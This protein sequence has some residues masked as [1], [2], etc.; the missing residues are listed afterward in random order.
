M[1][2]LLSGPDSPT[3]LTSQTWD[4]S[5]PTTPTSALSEDFR[6][7]SVPN[8]PEVASEKSVRWSDAQNT[9]NPFNWTDAKKWRVTI[10]ACFMTF[11][12]QLNGTMM[13][14]AA[15]QINVSFHVSDESFPHSYWP[16][17]SWNLGGAAAPLLGLPLM[18]NFGVR[19]S[20]LVSQ[21]LEECPA[22][23]ADCPRGHSRRSN[24]L[25]HSASSREKLCDLDRY[26]HH[27]W[28]VLGRTGEHHVRYCE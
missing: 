4:T 1:S 15:E 20:Y 27:H 17:L 2:T 12:I 24:Y 22:T 14:S 28:F 5:K 10:L 25:H 19:R 8:G 18:E 3:S 21:C 7:S 16:I 26:T 11:V 9:L 6:P 23:Y 13:T